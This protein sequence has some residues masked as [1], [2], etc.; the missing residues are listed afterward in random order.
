M[1]ARA[2]VA[3]ETKRQLGASMPVNVANGGIEA[4]RQGCQVIGWVNDEDGIGTDTIMTAASLVYNVRR[5]ERVM[6]SCMTYGLITINDSIHVELGFT[7]QANGAGSFTPISGHRHVL[8]GAAIAGFT[9][10]RENFTCP[11]PARYSEG[12]RSITFRVTANDIN[13]EV[14]LE[15]VG[16]IEKE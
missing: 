15:W 16:W 8:S 13:A 11:R 14:T 9:T 2:G 1:A 5:G 7:D 4:A 12:A 10:Q 3:H 6:I